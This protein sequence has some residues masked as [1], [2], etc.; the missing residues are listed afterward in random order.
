MKVVIKGLE[1]ELKFTVYAL[2]ELGRALECDVMSPAFFNSITH[3]QIVYMLWAGL[4]HETQHL[5]K[6]QQLKLEAVMNLV[7][8]NFKSEEF[9]AIHEAVLWAFLEAMGVAKEEKKTEPKPENKTKS[10]A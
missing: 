6:A 9:A 10:K 2:C 5:A 3:R 4:L 7:P 8:V 1:K